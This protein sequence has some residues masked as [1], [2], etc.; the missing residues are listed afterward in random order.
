MSWS[1]TGTVRWIWSRQIGVVLSEF[2]AIRISDRGDSHNLFVDDCVAIV[3]TSVPWAIFR[4]ITI[5]RVV[6]FL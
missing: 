1:R 3:P 2:V 4:A 6:D 5:E